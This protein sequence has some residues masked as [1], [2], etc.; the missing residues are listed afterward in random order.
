LAEDV[1]VAALSKY[2][3]DFPVIELQQSPESLEADDRPVA[4][5]DAIFRSFHEAVE[6]ALPGLLANWR[7]CHTDLAAFVE[8]NWG[9]ENHR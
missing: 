9:S 3:S 2:S 6:N 1:L 8:G 4:A 7:W 5:S